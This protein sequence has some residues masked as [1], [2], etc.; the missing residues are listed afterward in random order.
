MTLTDPD[1][2]QFPADC[3]FINGGVEI[4]SLE[5]GC[6]VHEEFTNPGLYCW[7]GVIEFLDGTTIPLDQCP[8]EI[9]ALPE[10]P[11]VQL[12]KTCEVIDEIAPGTIKWVIEFT[13]T[14]D[15]DWTTATLDDQQLEA[16]LGNPG[17]FPL[18]LPGP[19]EP[20]LDASLTISASDLAE[21]TYTNQA[22]IIVENEFGLSNS[23]TSEEVSCTILPNQID[24]DIDIKPGSFPNSIN[25]RSMGLVPVA[26]LGSEDFD[27][28]TIDVTTLMFGTA[29]PA[30]DLT[31][32]DTY[33]EHLQDVNED[34]W[35]DLVSHYK[36]KETG[37]GCF[38]T[39][40]TLSGNLL[41]T[42][43][44]PLIEGTDSVNP[45]CKP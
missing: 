33:F 36:Q 43:P 12:T 16:L 27:V 28:T 3:G 11:Q 15:T 42:G 22:T 1:G 6:I 37:I 40:A 26:I 5:S 32:L 24:V 23:A 25:T 45:K 9:L 2:N 7:T 39:E 4:Q 29:S 18:D 30:H 20:G 34:G 8:F 17:F 38:D 21:G 19:L 14:G 13:N 41:A 10:P 31:D 35:L 44:G